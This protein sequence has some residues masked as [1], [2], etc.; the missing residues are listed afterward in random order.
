MR[1]QR[2]ILDTPQW[3]KELDEYIE[4][5]KR[6][7]PGH[8]QSGLIQVLHHVQNKFGYVPEKAINHVAQALGV[9][10]VYVEGVASFY[11]YFSLEPKG[12]Y[13]ISV[14]LGTACY[15]QGSQ[16]VLDEFCRLLDVKPGGTTADGLFT[17]AEARCLGACGQAPVVMVNERVHARVKPED[18]ADI[19]AYY[20]AEA[21]ASAETVEA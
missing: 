2:Q 10:S 19:I 7:N 12:N 17:L 18:V 4:E 16:A 13:S 6:R 5:Q 1:Y 9:P 8:V 14:C 20:N 21:Q 15:V 3:W 11:S